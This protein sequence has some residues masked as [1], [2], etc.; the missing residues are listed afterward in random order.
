MRII[1]AT[2]E[3]LT[4]KDQERTRLVSELVS[5]KR[6]LKKYENTTLDDMLRKQRRIVDLTGIGF[7]LGQCSSDKKDKSLFEILKS[8]SKD[9]NQNATT[10]NVSRNEYFNQISND[11]NQVISS[12]SFMGKR[13]SNRFT[14]FFDGHCFMCHQYGHRISNCRYMSRRYSKFHLGYSFPKMNSLR[15]YKCN[16]FGHVMSN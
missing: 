12:T 15:C 4:S 10:S 6:K 8:E 2:K 16:L 1:F 5:Y 9:T 11:K 3:E 13:Y 14:S 7:E